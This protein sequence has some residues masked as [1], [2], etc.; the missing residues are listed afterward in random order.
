MYR[1]FNCGVGMIVV[2]APEHADEAVRRL[3]AAGEQAFRIG[4]VVADAEG[5]VRIR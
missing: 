4:G 1:T 5:K 3:G 2:T